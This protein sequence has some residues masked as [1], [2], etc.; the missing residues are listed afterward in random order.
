MS[1]AHSVLTELAD[2]SQFTTM[3]R[4][5][6]PEAVSVRLRFFDGSWPV[7]SLHA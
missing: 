2:L 5:P 6:A 4:L 1:A 7:A 3:H